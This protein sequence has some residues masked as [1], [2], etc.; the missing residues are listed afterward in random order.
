MSSPALPEVPG[1]DVRHRDVRARDIRFHV[2]EA[3]P[4][5]GDP[6]VL[7]HGWPQHWWTWR[8]LLPG[9]TAAGHRVVMPDL[10]GFGWSDA[11]PG[12]YDK[13]TLAADVVALLDALGLDRVRLVG[14]DWGAFAGFL[15]C[16]HAPQRI[17]RYVACNIIHPWFRPPKPS[18]ALFARTSYQFVLATPVVGERVL[19]RSPALIRTVLRRGAHPDFRWADGEREVFG[20]RFREPGHARAT[21][22]LY[23]TFLRRE[24]RELARGQYDGR[25]LT[26]PT[27]Y[28][29]GDADPVITPESLKTAAAHA[30]HLTTAVLERCGHFSTEEAPDALLERI[31]GHFAAGDEGPRD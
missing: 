13:E 26:V 3:G 21:S 22:A 5:D 15:A 18:P 12:N 8:K 10:R 25:R 1:V 23:R 9:L 17:E 20:D 2:A 11:P 4:A 6:I 19:R 30:D 7:V 16:L 27:L 29:T 24:L 14:H 28:L 31:L